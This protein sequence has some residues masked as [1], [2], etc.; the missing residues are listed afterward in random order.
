MYK[1]KIIEIFVSV[2]DFCLEFEHEIKK[3]L[4]EGNLQARRNR[5][6]RLSNSEIITIQILFHFGAF[7]NFKHFYINYVCKHMNAEF[8]DLVSYNRFIEL[9]PK[10]SIAF[11][12]YVKHCCLGKC[13]GINFV[14]STPLRVCHNR[15]IHNH[16]VFTSCAERG[17]CSLGW[18]FGFKLHLI[19]NDR[20]EILAFYLTKG[21][22]DDRDVKVMSDM[23]NNLFGKLFG[24]KGYISKALSELLFQ[25]GI[26]LITKV[27]K[28]MKKQILTN[29]E[30]IL[31]R[32]RSVIETVNDEL[33]N[34]CQLEHTRHR[35]INSFLSNILSALA[36]YSFF[37][38]KPSIYVEFDK[39]Q[40]NQLALTAA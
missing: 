10:C 39:S 28:N 25:D 17:H 19:I 32:K 35:S 26:Q 4:L 12:L 16:K 15:R 36:A 33:K 40:Q 34:M 3:H 9:Q 24:D 8:P 23:T 14:D 21:N 2:D 1:D 29:E 7:R 38:K 30:K 18:F 11:M 13:T 5:K 31:L 37:P 20:G 22:V 27:R 6:S